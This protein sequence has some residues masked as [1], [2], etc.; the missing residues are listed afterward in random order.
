MDV[1]RDAAI[2]EDLDAAEELDT[3]QKVDEPVLLLV[4]EE[5]RLVRNPRN[6]VVALASLNDPF[7]PRD[8]AQATTSAAP[9][10]S[11]YSQTY[12]DPFSPIAPAHATPPVFVMIVCVLYKKILGNASGV[13][14]SK[15]QSGQT[16][17]TGPIRPLSWFS[18]SYTPCFAS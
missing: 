17:R 7:P 4:G 8:A 11:I 16:M 14:T 3:H 15:A 13:R 2:G 10:S 9:K 1:F 5:E 6:Q 18:R 12:T